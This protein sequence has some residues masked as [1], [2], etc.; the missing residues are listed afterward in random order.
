M[1]QISECSKT[2]EALMIMQEECAEVIQAISKVFRFGDDSK[3]PTEESATTKEELQ[4]EVGQVLAMVDVLVKQG[5][6]SDEAL[7][8]ARIAKHE[9]LKVW[10]N[11]YAS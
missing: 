3:W 11:I 5:Y 7:N 10:S 2:K 6:I 8:A 1:M 4:M 9:K